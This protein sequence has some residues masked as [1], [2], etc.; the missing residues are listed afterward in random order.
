MTIMIQSNVYE[1][2][3]SSCIT[4]KQK[5]QSRSPHGKYFK[6]WSVY[7]IS[8]Y[9]MKIVKSCV[10]LSKISRLVS[11]LIRTNIKNLLWSIPRK[12]LKSAP[13]RGGP[14]GHLITIDFIL[15]RPSFGQHFK[16][17]NSSGCTVSFSSGH[18]TWCMG[19]L[20]RYPS[21]EFYINLVAA[22]IFAIVSFSISIW[23][24]SY[25]ILWR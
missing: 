15:T 2:R 4:Y 19:K 1:W 22:F 18:Y 5:T 8:F 9:L 3:S 23:T 7:H 16:Q 14:W 12:S 10:V 13:E 25:H 17:H 21:G 11:C 20:K 24:T 6:S